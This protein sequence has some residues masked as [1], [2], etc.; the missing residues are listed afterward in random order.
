MEFFH[1]HFHL[2]AFLALETSADMSTA[3]NRIFISSKS[4]YDGKSIKNFD[5][6]FWL[7]GASF[8]VC[9]IS[10]LACKCLLGCKCPTKVAHLKKYEKMLIEKEPEIAP[11]RL[12]ETS[13]EV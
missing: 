4:N 10:L 6:F 9:L 2:F 5:I 7:F 12:D 3:E 11:Y 8:M 13:V 1:F